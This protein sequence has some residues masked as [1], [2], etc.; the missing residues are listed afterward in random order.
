VD[1]SQP[2]VRILMNRRFILLLTLAASTVAGT[3]HAQFN[4]RDPA[5]GETYRV[6]FAYGWWR[7]EPTIGIASEGLGIPPTLIDFETDLGIG[8]QRVREFRLVLRPGRKHKLKLDYLPISYKVEGHVL[9]RTIVFNGQSYLVGLPV[10]VDA[11]FTTLKIGYEYDFIYKDR[12]YLGFVL[13]TKVTRAKIDF[14]SPINDEFAE[15]TAPIPTLGFAGRAYAARNVAVGGEM[16]FFKIPGGD[17]RDY[18]GSY[19]DY[20]FYATLNFNNNVGVTGGW[21][22][23]DLDYTVEEDFGSL[24]LRGLYVLGVVRF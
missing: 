8:K 14:E 24:D 5:T 3:A 7:P 6:E 12:G 13:D 1:E 20:D 17:D 15:A 9:S 22:K 16:T 11:D 2:R 18:D 21:R 4:R 10:N 19:Y 23:L